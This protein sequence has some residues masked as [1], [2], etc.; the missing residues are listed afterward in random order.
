MTSNP[1]VHAFDEVANHNHIND[2]W[3]IISGKVYDVTPFMDDHPGGAEIL[4]SATGKHATVEFEQVI[5]SS[6]ASEM[7]EKYY[8][9]EVDS[10]TIPVGIEEKFNPHPQ[11]SSESNKTAGFAIMIIRLLVPLLILGLAVA[12]AQFAKK[13]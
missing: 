8:V 6:S 4:L 5:H 12:V 10:S 7:M 3:I 1:K 11:P 9:G 13:D 2:C